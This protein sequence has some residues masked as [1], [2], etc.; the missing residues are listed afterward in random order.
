MSTSVSLHPINYADIPALAKISGDCFL[1]DRHTQMKALGKNPY[2]HEEGMKGV[3]A[4]YVASE[5]CVPLKAVD[6]S[7]G[8][9]LGWCGFGFRGFETEDIPK[10]APIDEPLPTMVTG[11][12]EEN[13]KTEEPVE[14][15]ED[16][17]IKRETEMTNADMNHWMAKLMPPGTKC[18]YLIG[19]NVAPRYQRRGIGQ[20]MLNWGAD[21]ADKSGVFTWVHSSE[22]AWKMY[23]KA[24]F[25]VIGSLDINLDDWAPAPAPAEE[26]EGAIWGHYVLRYMKRLPKVRKESSE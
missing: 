25:D 10:T 26:G 13:K 15:E 3:I 9:L 5:R 6:D 16:D 22:G 24:G 12:I 7:T 17:I 19:L 14:D 18:M 2:K 21:V 20:T 11:A 8:E 4:S 23:E 1:E